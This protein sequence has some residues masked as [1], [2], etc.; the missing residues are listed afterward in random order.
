MNPYQPLIDQLYREK[1]LRA[2]A[3]AGGAN[4]RCAG[5]FGMVFQQGRFGASAPAANRA[6]HGRARVLRPAAAPAL[7]PKEAVLAVL[8]EVEL[9]GGFRIVRPSACAGRGCKRNW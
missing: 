9:D 1:I 4:E 8:N 6:D 3:D 2:A 5:A 7:T